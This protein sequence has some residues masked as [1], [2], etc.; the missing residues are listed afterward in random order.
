MNKGEAQ[1]GVTAA[2]GTTKARIER[3]A[4][5]LFARRG[6]DVVTTRDI[7]GAAGVSEGAIYKHYPSK[8]ALA[9]SLRAVP[10]ERLAKDIRERAAHVESVDEHATAIVDAFA[11]A[12][13]EDWP[14]FCY[15][16]L[17]AHAAPRRETQTSRETADP[18]SE[19]KKIVQRA[20]DAGA[21]PK[22]NAALKAAMATGVILQIARHKIEGRVS[23]DF[24][25]HADAMKNSVCAILRAKA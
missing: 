2:P 14:L 7:A 18:V 21:L 3:A 24:S 19:V 4:V 23:G 22:G 6:P 12:A 11:H 8:A 15:C 16:F 5:A 10:L 25:G 17:T 9:A 13:D 20:M 1:W